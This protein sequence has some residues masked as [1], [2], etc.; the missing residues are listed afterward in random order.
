MGLFKEIEDDIKEL[1]HL[2]ELI[3][4]YSECLLFRSN[5]NDKYN[6]NPQLC[7]LLKNKINILVEKHEK[8]KIK[9]IN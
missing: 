1:R 6:Y 3:R 9:L 2:S 7:E 4:K 8:L 5:I